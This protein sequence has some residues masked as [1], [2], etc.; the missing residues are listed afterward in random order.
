LYDNRL[1]DLSGSIPDADLAAAL[2]A[3]QRR[4][5]GDCL[6]LRGGMN[7]GPAMALLENL[8]TTVLPAGLYVS[9]ATH[10]KDSLVKIMMRRIGRSA[11]VSVG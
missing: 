9:L 3:S 4:R 11:D 2:S 7:G 1:G 8:P 10:L 5:L 6:L